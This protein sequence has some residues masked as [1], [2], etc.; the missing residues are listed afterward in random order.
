LQ[1]QIVPRFYAIEFDLE[2]MFRRAIEV[3]IEGLRVR[4]LSREDLTLVLCIHAAKHGW[5]HLGMLRDIAAL[6]RFELDWDWISC[7]ARQRGIITILVI[8][9]ALTQRFLTRALPETIGEKLADV[10]YVADPIELKLCAGGEPDTQS[11]RY[12]RQFARCR[13]RWQDRV[14]FWARLALTPSVGEWE[15]VRVPDWLF[16]A[17]RAVRI[18]RL[19]K[20]AVVSR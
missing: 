20:R 6:V 2:A 5:A 8:S 18:S 7:E 9:L 13:E 4:S 19:L 10:E 1:W 16:P 11:L 3:E 14:R 15:A 17:Y 12:F